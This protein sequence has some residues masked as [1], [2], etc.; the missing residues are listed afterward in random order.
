MR[1]ALVTDI[2][3]PTWFR[4]WIRPANCLGA[5]ERHK[6]FRTGIN[7]AN[8]VVI[9]QGFKVTKIFCQLF[10]GGKPVVHI[11]AGKIRFKFDPH[12]FHL[13]SAFCA[14]LNYSL[15]ISLCIAAK[16]GS[17]RDC[18]AFIFLKERL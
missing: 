12:V 16:I 10:K 7:K 5:L 4:V 6:Q 2:V 11:K 9:T 13:S 3:E 15:I 8:D 17:V 14:C 1:P 18:F